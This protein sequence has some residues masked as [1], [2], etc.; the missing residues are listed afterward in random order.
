MNYEEIFSELQQ[1]LLSGKWKAGQRLPS[2]R[3]LSEYYGVSRPTVSRALNRLRDGGMV[4][5]LTGAGTFVLGEDLIKG[6]NHQTFG[7]MVPGLG[8]GEIFEPI[9]ARIA[10]KSRQYD[11]TLIW[12]G[13][14]ADDAID[15][16]EHLLATAERLVDSAVTGVFFQPVERESEALKKNLEIVAI[17]EKAKIPITLLDS[18]YLPFPNRSGHDLVGI[19][20]VEAAYILTNHF[21]ELG[22]RRVDFVWPPN[23]AGT[24]IRRRIGY[25]H[26]LTRAGIE[27][28]PEFEHEGDPQSTDFAR[29]LFERGGRD[30]VCLND[31]T[32][33][34]LMRTFEKLGLQSPHDIRIAGFDDVKFA[35][36]A[37]VPLTTMK[38]PCQALGDIAL[39]TM[40]DR[41]NDPWLPPR[42]VTARAT[43]CVREST[44][45]RTS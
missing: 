17:F 36:L 44:G 39:R 8:R 41:I 27:F 45:L 34:N 19:D 38:Q 9:C 25:Q 37:P 33:V 4:R 43:L 16:E 40:I 2:E 31:E 10:E 20:N 14:P 6:S 23:A 18:D 24:H 7:L 1:Q 21:L 12:G 35:R 42:T 11:F 28:L 29:A 13:I 32:A 22:Q 3:E 30:I 5:R 26:A 15:H